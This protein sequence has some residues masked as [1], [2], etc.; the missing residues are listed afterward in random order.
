MVSDL[1][2]PSNYF[3][4]STLHLT[5]SL[6]REEEAGLEPELVVQI[7]R[8]SK[9]PLDIRRRVLGVRVNVVRH[10]DRNVLHGLGP[11]AMMMPAV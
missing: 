11:R 7:E 5:G 4:S 1:V 3:P 8:V 2:P 10:Q 6:G 9:I